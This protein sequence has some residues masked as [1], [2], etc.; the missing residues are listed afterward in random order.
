[1]ITHK[2]KWLL[3]GLVCLALWPAHAPAQGDLW[4]TYMDA[5]AKAYQQGNYPEAEK[6]WAAAV[7]EAEGF[8]P[9]DPRL[10]TNLNNL[11]ELYRAQGRYAEA[12]PLHYP[13][14]APHLPAD[15]WPG[16]ERIS[17]SLRNRLSCVSSQDSTGRIE[18]SFYKA[19]QAL[20]ENT[21]QFLSGED[22][23]MYNLHAALYQM[24][25]ALELEIS[26]LHAEIAH[27]SQQV[28]QIQR[29]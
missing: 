17:A 9:Q 8:G 2:T 7:K 25:E 15:W 24:A 10:A 4:E 23:A 12:E 11:G 1:M 20:K 6:Q 13:R 18:M 21:K 27:I 29:R 19:K 5:G 26:R 22:P 3:V 14:Q 28:A 16:S